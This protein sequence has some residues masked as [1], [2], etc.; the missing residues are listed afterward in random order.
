[1]AYLAGKQGY[2]RKRLIWRLEESRIALRLRRGRKVNSEH[3]S[4]QFSIDIQLDY[5]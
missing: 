4:T 1:M 3:R 5:S 2:G